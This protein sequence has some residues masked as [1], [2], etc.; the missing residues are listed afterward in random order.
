MTKRWSDIKALRPVSD[1][2][3]SSAH[4]ENLAEDFGLALSHLR[5]GEDLTQVELAHRLLVTQPTV[6]EMER[7]GS[8][9][10]PT[11]RRYVEAVGA[12]LELVAVFDD[13]RR[14]ALDPG[15][16]RSAH[17]PTP[18]E[19][20][21]PGVRTP[22]ITVGHSKSTRKGS[23]MATKKEST[24]K[25]AAA[26]AAKTLQSKS[27]SKA[28]KSAAGSALSQT[29]STGVTSKAAASSAAKTLQSKSASKAAKSAA[30]SAL[31][32]RP[33]KPGKK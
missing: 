26:A 3:L 5:R 6:S 22:R 16:P 30:G 23:L 21:E 13:G 28:A 24:G 25:P 20:M 31:T 1:E 29:K 7:S 18:T 2:A 14:V 12:R 19:M 11:V 27:A 17:G 10:V 9:S 4:L 32:Q 8:P 33:S 15:S